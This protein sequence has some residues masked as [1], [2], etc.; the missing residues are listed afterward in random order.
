[1]V[2]LAQLEVLRLEVVVPQHVEV[3]LDELGSLLLDV[4]DAP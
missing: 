2:R 1:L 4:D 3:V